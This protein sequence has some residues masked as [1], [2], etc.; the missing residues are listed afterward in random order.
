MSNEQAGL[1]NGRESSHRVVRRVTQAVAGAASAGAAA[2]V[3]AAVGHTSSAATHT[4]AA[5]VQK[6]KSQAASKERTGWYLMRARRVVSLALLTGVFVL[7]IATFRR[8]RPARLLRARVGA[9][10]WQALHR[11]AYVSW[12]LALAH[13]FG[14]GSDASALWLQAVGIACG[15][16]VCAAVLWRLA[17][18]SG[19]KHLE[20]RVVSP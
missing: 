19:V 4:V 10:T 8:W 16:S 18:P 14:I 3:G 9:R 6:A 20:P 12:P 13:S 5:T 1:V 11:T 15:L 2:I 17:A 7:G